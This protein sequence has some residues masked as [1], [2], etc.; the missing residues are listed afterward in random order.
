[1]STDKAPTSTRMR[2]RARA[3]S[4]VICSSA[5]ICV[6][7]M[8]WMMHA[9]LAPAQPD[10]PPARATSA[11]MSPAEAILIGVVEGAT[12]FLPISSTG[13]L[14]V[15][16]RL[17]GARNTDADKGPADAYA[18]AVQIGA[19]LAVLVLYRRRLAGLGR[20][21]VTREESGRRL[22]GAVAIAVTPTV[23][24]GV[25]FEP[26]IKS[27]LLAV[28]PVLLAW[29]L[30]GVLILAIAP[31]LRGVNHGVALELITYRQALVIGIVQCAALWP[32]TS[33]S[34]VTILAALA[35]G[36]SLA[37]AVEF[38]FLIG[39]VTLGAATVFEV[40][41]DGGSVVHA[42]GWTTP[43]IGA[44][45]AFVTAVCA[46]RWMV[47]YLQSHSLAIF[48]WYRLGIATIVVLLA[49]TALGPPI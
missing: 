29:I 47:N 27:H 13:H 45:V 39:F 24:A 41:K 38:S 22:L 28:E 43:I 32:G 46:I 21:L 34:L 16:Q 9:P 42:Y 36:L 10:A 11:A 23:L 44:I 7:V 37:A 12:E 6:A 20:G 5:T 3:P 48:G 1:M 4:L 33:R 30:G 15:T 26:L 19:V 17:L 49:A 40:V 31:R 35:A 2:L 18:I 14:I 25:A 8:G